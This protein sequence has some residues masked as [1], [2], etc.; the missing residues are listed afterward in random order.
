M[1][2]TVVGYYDTDGNYS[3]F[4]EAIPVFRFGDSYRDK[5]GM[6]WAVKDEYGDWVN[7]NLIGIG[8]KSVIKI[9]QRTDEVRS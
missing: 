3:A 4:R 6:A 2:H 7:P 1:N 8:V 9:E 5:D